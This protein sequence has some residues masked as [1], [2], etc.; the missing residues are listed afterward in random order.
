MS[1][2]PTPAISMLWTG[3][4]KH[5]IAQARFEMLETQNPDSAY[6][7]IRPHVL[8]QASEL[9]ARFPRYVARLWLRRMP[10]PGSF[11]E[12]STQ[13]LAPGEQMDRRREWLAEMYHTYRLLESVPQLEWRTMDAEDRST[14]PQHNQKVFYF[15]EIVGAHPGNFYA[16]ADDTLPDDFTGG[17]RF[18]SASGFLDAFDVSHWAPRPV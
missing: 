2:L 4:E 15:F 5:K 12:L 7:E 8:P 16:K 17:A 6:S 13:V 18:E 3:I 1:S 14:W 10:T 11:E 9:A